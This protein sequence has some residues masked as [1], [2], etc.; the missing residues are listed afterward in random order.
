MSK[1]LTITILSLLMIFIFSCK[2]EKIKEKT[3][4]VNSKKYSFVEKTTKVEFTAYKT[5]KKVPVKGV[6]T[7][8]KINNP[9]NAS[10]AIEAING[11]NFSIPINSIETENEDRDVKIANSFFGSMKETTHLT[12]S[13]TINNDEKYI[14]LKMNGISSKIPVEYSINNQIVTIEGTLNLD[15]WKTKL[16]ID[17]LNLVCKD[18]HKGEDG[19]SKTWS[20]VAIKIVTALKVE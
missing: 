10:S 13:T 11:L 12:G 9:K 8:I 15:N 5:T 4:D 1:K 14:L 19:I 2:K 20:E 18:L 3:T 6:F 17:A 16:A 7:T